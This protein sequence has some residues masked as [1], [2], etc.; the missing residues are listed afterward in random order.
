MHVDTNAITCSHILTV[1]SGPAPTVLQVHIDRCNWRKGLPR[2]PDWWRWEDWSGTQSIQQ[3]RWVDLT[4]FGINYSATGLLSSTN[5]FFN[6]DMSRLFRWWN[7][8]SWEWMR[9]LL[10]IMAT[11]YLTTQWPG[12]LQL[13]CWPCNPEISHLSTR[14]VSY[15]AYSFG[16][17]NTRIGNNWTNHRPSDHFPLEFNGNTY[18]LDPSWSSQHRLRRCSE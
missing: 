12:H 18:G 10:D 6:L 5:T 8:S 3:V 11:N 2:R 4:W 7:I 14:M 16:D 15:R 9:R 1:Y 13:W 17:Q